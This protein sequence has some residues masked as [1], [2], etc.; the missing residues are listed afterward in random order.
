VDNCQNSCDVK[1]R[2]S[3]GQKMQT[4]GV[5]LEQL[6]DIIGFSIIVDDIE[7]CY[8]V[9]GLF[10]SNWSTIPGGFKDYISTPKS[11]IINQYIQL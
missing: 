5:S 4:K 9:L 7:T 3:I 1:K 10:H 2:C 6:T 8:K 11:I